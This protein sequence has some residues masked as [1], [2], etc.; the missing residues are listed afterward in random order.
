MHRVLA[1]WSPDPL[2]HHVAPLGLAAS[3]G[4]CLVVDL[5]ASAP[6]LGR[7]TLRQVIDSGLTATDLESGTGVAVVANGGVSPAEAA[8]VVA[9]LGR[10]WGRVVY[11]AGPDRVD[12]PV[13]PIHPLLP[14]PFRPPTERCV[15]QATL[16]G[17]SRGVAPVTLPPLR[18]SQILAMLHGSIEP[19][20]RW[21]RACRAIWSVPWE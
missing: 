7:R 3:V 11:R 5:D 15:V 18:R 1:T 4:S 2:L 14:G 21:V 12:A 13:V 6:P 20:W 8:T 19:R 17:R 9:A 16:S 10:G